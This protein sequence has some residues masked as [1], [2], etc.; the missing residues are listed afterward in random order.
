MTLKNKISFSGQDAMTGK[1]V[2]VELLPS[3]KLEIMLNGEII[4][5]TPESG[6][7]MEG[8]HTSAVS[9]GKVSVYGV[10]HLFSA[11]WGM[12]IDTCQICLNY[13]TIPVL[14]ASAEK[15]CELLKNNLD[16][17]IQPKI[18]KPAE[19]FWWYFQDS[20]AFFEP[21][22]HFSLGAFLQFPEPIGEDY[23]RFDPT[24][25]DYVETIA[26]ARTFMRSNCTPEVWAR[27]R[28]KYTILPED[29]KLSPI[30]L[31]EGDHWLVAPNEHEPVKHKILDA[32]GDPM[33][34][35]KRIE[36]KVTLIRPG[37]DFT[38]ELVKYLSKEVIKE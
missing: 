34:L 6:V 11:F 14:D 29:P 27:I 17:T 10:E 22:D 23:Y 7:S 38:R 30:P 16:N 25:E 19:K 2:N 21:D 26:P 12:G 18:F 31:A 28:S 9:N 35:G 13:N 32:I 36:A 8:F 5:V 1:I 20:A 24:K 37:H 15:L 4:P 3:D 33:F